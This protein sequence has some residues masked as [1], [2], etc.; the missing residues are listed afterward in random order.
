[1]IVQLC[2]RSKCI[3]H[4]HKYTNVLMNYVH[5]FLWYDSYPT[6]F[7]SLQPCGTSWKRKKIVKKLW[8]THIFLNIKLREKLNLQ[9]HTSRCIV[10]WPSVFL[11]LSG[12][13]IHL[14]SIYVWSKK[15]KNNN[16]QGS[17]ALEILYKP[18]C[19]CKHGSKFQN[20]E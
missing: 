14:I 3:F 16:M 10:S 7:D 1:M 13:S 8:H 9:I 18:I 19:L 6:C 15:K 17:K 12:L 4:K 20:V 2:N 5:Y 11:H